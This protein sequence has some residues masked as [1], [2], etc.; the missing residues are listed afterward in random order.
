MAPQNDICNSSVGPNS[1]IQLRPNPGRKRPVNVLLVSPS[2]EENRALSR[3]LNDSA[4]RLSRVSGY[5][6]AI[7]YLT[8][9]RVAIVVCESE[10]PDGSWRDILLDI[11]SYSAPPVLIVTSRQAD[12]YLWA[13]VLNLGGY[14]LLAK[15]FDDEEVRRVIANACTRIKVSSRWSG[16]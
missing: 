6:E 14:D 1:G 16:A 9:N 3:I 8:R 2:A 11:R 10:L 4:W 5:E 15:P 12:E 7:T 13:E